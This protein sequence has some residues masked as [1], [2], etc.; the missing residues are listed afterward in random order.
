MSKQPK[1]VKAQTG[2]K[3]KT[4]K[5][6]AAKRS[7]GQRQHFELSRCSKLYLMALTN[8]FGVFPVEPCVPDLYDSPSKKVSILFR[9]TLVVPTTGNGFV[10][11]RIQDSLF[12][13]I[14]TIFTSTNAYAGDGIPPLSTT[15]GTV[16]APV[17][18][19]LYQSSQVGTSSASVQYRLVGGG[20]RVRY[21]GTELNRGGLVIPFSHPQNQTFTGYS[22]GSL[23]SF[24]TTRLEPASRGWHGICWSPK[25]VTDYNYYSGAVA[26]QSPGSDGSIA[27]VVQSSGAQMTWQFEQVA[28]FEVTGAVDTPTRSDSDM[29]GM[30]AIRSVLEGGF[31]GD[32][33]T[34]LYTEAL[35]LVNS[36]GP[37]TISGF[38][39]G[40]AKA[41]TDLYMGSM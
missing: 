38:V 40:A 15:T 29:Q 7:V 31:D 10:V 9:G 33:S 24:R 14:N 35:K 39:S 32:P 1:N 3:K 6:K 22:V 30:S 13:N 21:I 28:H 36:L 16:A 41:A 11:S 17:T 5:K 37:N 26:T 8:P 23:Q 19:G 2:N 18:S 34:G 20:L 12:N 27:I 4:K 25:R